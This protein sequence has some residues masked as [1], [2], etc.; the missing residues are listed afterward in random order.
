MADNNNILR[1]SPTNFTFAAE[2]GDYGAAQ[3]AKESP[4][5]LLEMVIRMAS[6]NA[7]QREARNY[8]NRLPKVMAY[9]EFDN[10]GILQ[11]KEVQT[12]D[13]AFVGPG[14][15]AG[16]STV[17]GLGVV[18]ILAADA[19]MEGAAPFV[20]ARDAVKRREMRGPMES[21]PFFT[22]SVYLK[23]SAPGVEAVDLAQDIGFSML[24]CNTF[25]AMAKI[26]REVIKDSATNIKADALKEIG[27]AQEMTL[28][29]WVFTR[30]V[31]FA[32]QTVGV[33]AT[34]GDATNM[35]DAVLLAQAKISAY[36]YA[37]RDAVLWPMGHYLTYSKLIPMYNERAQEQIEG[38]RPLKY[39]DM[40]FHKTSVS[41][42][43]A[44]EVPDVATA[45]TFDGTT[46]STA[47]SSSSIWGLV[48]E[49]DRAGE[50]GLLEDLEFEEFS[51]PIK[52]LECPI[53]NTRWDF[54]CAKDATKTGRTNKNAVAAIYDHS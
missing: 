26:G 24:N 17:K 9:G 12:K 52:Y 8:M 39:G 35:I 29:R 37:A 49:K 7:T 51:D 2:A 15:G 25:R 44:Y 1:K 21:M 47:K 14:S 41:A 43:A 36:G 27:K 45:Y 11:V 42:A 20:C 6:G 18:P 30:M 3:Y 16:S 38:S 19:V 33:A 28:N 31:D 54:Q 4:S 13:L 48:Y 53:V 50:L 46:A 23:P 32:N 5:A 40:T 10:S 22:S 34:G